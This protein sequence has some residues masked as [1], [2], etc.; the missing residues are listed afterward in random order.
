MQFFPEKYRLLA[1]LSVLLLAG[2][3]TTSLVSYLVSRHNI[4]Q[5]ITNNSLP[6]TSDNIYSEIQKDILQPIFISSLMAH[7]TFVRDWLLAGEKDQTAI[8]RYLAEVKNKYNMTS[9]SLVSEASRNYY[10]AD[11]LLKQVSEKEKRDIWYFRVREMPADYEINVDVDMANRD[12]VTIF[13][14]H[15]IAD[16]HCNFLGTTGV[17][18]TLDTMARLIDSYESR[19][20]RMV[21]FINAQGRVM[22]SGKAAPLKRGYL[23]SV[24]GLGSLESR[25]L[26]NDPTPTRLSYDTKDGQVMVSSRFIPEL[27]WYL[28][29]EQNEAESLQ[30]LRNVLLF[31]LSV[32]LMISVLVLL[33]AW[34]A[35]RRYQARLERMATNDALTGSLNRQ[36][37]EI[38]FSSF[39]RNAS[40]TKHTLSAILFD[41]DHFKQINDSAGH[42]AGDAVLRELAE[43]VRISLRESDVIARWGGEEFMVL[44]ND[45]DLAKAEERAEALRQ[46]ID[47]HD[48]PVGHVTV[49]L[50]V[51]E[52]LPGEGETAFF[53]RID[54]A[55]YRAKAQ[56]RNRTETA[57]A[58]VFQEA[59]P[60]RS[61]V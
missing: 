35:I 19:F 1:W 2:F 54:Q 60:S 55:L 31:N 34:L 10:Y 36:A 5:N 52:Y 49:S 4:R 11:G 3:L 33:I 53:A 61:S 22:L 48:F 25:I 21:Y 6:L 46:R 28:V 44:L 26:N 45:C 59:A 9:S 20:H 41:V 47:R 23:S 30:S 57:L 15:K 37:F 58:P 7:D 32:A 18:L 43:Q 17:G 16:Y 24:Q 42:L 39:V 50:G 38:V 14:N 27:G 40:R 12:A 8:V 13:I 51:A 29:V 56:G